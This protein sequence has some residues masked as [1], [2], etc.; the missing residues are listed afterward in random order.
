[1]R[2]D[3]LMIEANLISRLDRIPMNKSILGIVV[4]LAWCWVM[5]A[6]DIGMISQVVLV[7]R[8]IWNLDANTLGLLGSCSTAGVVIGTVSLGYLSDKYGRKKI[9]LW[10]TFVFTF[11]TLIGSL[12]ENL[13]W[14]ITMRFLSGLGAGVV[15]PLPYLMISELAPAKKRAV[16]V[17][18]CNAIL[19]CAYLLPTLAGS[20][21]IKTFS[22]DY[23]WRV[24]FII[25]GIPIVT[26][27]ILNKYLPESPR[28][29]MKRGRHDEVRKLVERFEKSAG[30]EHD[31]TF[32]DEIVL[33]SLK[34]MAEEGCV[35]NNASWKNLFIPP[36]LSRTLVSWGMF[37][38]GLITWYV[39]MVYVPTIL[40]T[41]GFDPSKSLVLGGIMA[42]VSGGGALLMGPLADK[43]GRKSIWSLYVIIS[44]VCLFA[45]T[46][47]TSMNTL[48]FVGAVMSFF[49][50]G[51]MPVCKLY[52]AEQYPTEL[53]SLGTGLDEAVS[54]IIGGVLATYYLAYFVSV[55]GVNAVFIFMAVTFLIAVIA[56]LVWGR[57]TAGRN[58]EDISSC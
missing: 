49:G 11:F 32:I 54:R 5:E 12:M 19:A 26:I 30:V 27:L 56:L 47:I 14:I 20:W 8:K 44:V 10:G 53:R 17:C 58:V 39:I 7:L 43:Y 13:A 35:N 15:F 18:I 45:M 9:L 31:D 33:N 57:E 41:Y 24:P 40:T 48:L 1:M 16:L 21:A 51:I 29:L 2:S 22:L 6:F 36:Y 42:A 52:I 50:A 25:G 28:W 38:A 46:L 23:A 37:S 4:L 55:G 3:T 34:K